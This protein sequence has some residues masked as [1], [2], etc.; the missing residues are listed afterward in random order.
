MKRNDQIFLL[1]LCDQ[2][3]QGVFEERPAPLNIS[4]MLI[5]PASA[6]TITI[7]NRTAPL[8]LAIA[9]VGVVSKL[10]IKAAIAIQITS[11]AI[12]RVVSRI[13]S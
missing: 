13:M 9:P 3:V 7:P 12:I 4:G 6:I 8:A 10:P 5:T 2:L 11:V 1:A